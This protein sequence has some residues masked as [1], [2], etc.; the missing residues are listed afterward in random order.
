MVR[1]EEQVEIV[2]EEVKD[3]V[4]KGGD[5]NELVSLEGVG[6]AALLAWGKKSDADFVLDSGTR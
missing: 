5:I 2:G 3:G 6:G 1:I 4:E